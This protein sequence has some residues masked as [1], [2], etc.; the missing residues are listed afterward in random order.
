MKKKIKIKAFSEEEIDRIVVAQAD[1]DSA[2]EKP[3]KVKPA[4]SS[5]MHSPSELAVRAAF[6][7]R[8]PEE[9]MAKRY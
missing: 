4:K 7:V 9:D 2:W 8:L 5:T 1:D 6:F 3:V